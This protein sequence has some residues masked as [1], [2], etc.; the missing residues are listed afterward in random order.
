ML[1]GRQSDIKSHAFLFPF[2]E[3]DRQ[4]ELDTKQVN[5]NYGVTVLQ[6]PRDP[7]IV[8]TKIYRGGKLRP[9]EID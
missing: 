8:E 5:Q 2:S 3:L 9:G 7:Q 4:H 1:I 6:G